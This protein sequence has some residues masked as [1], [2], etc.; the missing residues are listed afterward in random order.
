MTA[1]VLTVQ[2]VIDRVQ[3]TFGDESAAQV[4]QADIIRWIN[5]AQREAVMQNEGLL[6]TIGYVNTVAG[7]GEY[8]LPTDLFVLTHAYVKDSTSTSYYAIKWLPLVE[9]TEQADGWD[10]TSVTNAY[11]LVF[12]QQQKDKILLF[13]KPVASVAQGLKVIY[14]RYAVDVVDTSSTIDLPPY[15]HTF[16]VN[17]CLMQA[18]EMDEDWESAQQ[19][20]QQVQGDLDFNNSRQYWFGR[21]TYPSVSTTYQDFE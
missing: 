13:P 2:D 15:L 18:Y 14:S 12:T 16:V 8:S 1:G 3:R 11:P 4:T 6:T 19:K 9:F 21:E 7:T 10:S 17:F 20:A 5:D